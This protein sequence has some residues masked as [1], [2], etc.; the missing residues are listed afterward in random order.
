MTKEEIM[1]CARADVFP[2]EYMTCPETTLYYVLRDIYRAYRK[3]SISAEKGEKQRNLAIRQFEFNCNELDFARKILMNNAV[4]WQL[5]EAARNNYRINRTLENADALVEAWD[6]AK[7][8]KDVM[9][10]E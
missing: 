6:G 4:M 9:N 1:K 7:A 8:R 2:T 3:G 5:T 10:V